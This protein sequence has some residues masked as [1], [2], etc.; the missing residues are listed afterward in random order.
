MEP[1]LLSE[2]KWFCVNNQFFVSLIRPTDPLGEILMEGNAVKNLDTNRTEQNSGVSGKATFSL[3]ILSP[4]GKAGSVRKFEFEVYAGPKDYKLLTGLGSDQ[5]KVMQFGVFWWVSEPLSYLLDVFSGIFGSYG[6]GIIVLTILIKLIL[7]PLTAKATKSQKKCRPYRSP[8]L[9][10][11]K[12]QRQPQKLN[13]EMMKF[14]KEH[15][16]I[17]LPVAGQS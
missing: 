1:K 13:Q 10:F 4:Q 12:T 16:A 5:N 15:K 6:L 7:W 9:P 17:H 14:Y 3:G 2:A 8:W 11:A